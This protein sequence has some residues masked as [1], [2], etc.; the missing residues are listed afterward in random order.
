MTLNKRSRVDHVVS[1]MVAVNTHMVVL[2]NAHRLTRIGVLYSII[3]KLS[4]IA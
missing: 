4:V 1:L 2:I 3:A